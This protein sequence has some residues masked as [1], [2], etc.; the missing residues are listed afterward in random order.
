MAELVWQQMSY[1]FV[2]PDNH[3]LFLVSL[4]NMTIR[5]HPQYKRDRSPLI[6]YVL[7]RDKE[8]VFLVET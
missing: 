1:N 3:R 6:P 2:R 5:Y 8:G 7:T 4:V